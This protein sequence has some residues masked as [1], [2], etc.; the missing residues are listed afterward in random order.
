VGEAADELGL[1]R[2]IRLFM[3]I[4][5]AAKRTHRQTSSPDSIDK[6]GEPDAFQESGS[7]CVTPSGVANSWN[8]SAKLY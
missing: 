2:G 7:C 5:E 1:V 8:L 6:A 4:R 3:I